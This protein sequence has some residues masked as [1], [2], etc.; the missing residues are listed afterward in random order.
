[1]TQLTILCAEDDPDDRLLL[2]DAMAE[3][4]GP[5]H[6]EFVEDGLDLL[7][8]L[9]SGGRWS[10]AEQARPALI[11]L[12]LNMPRMDGREALRE[13][14]ADPAIR[15]IPVVVMTTSGAEADVSFA[16]DHGASS[17]VVKPVTFDGLVEAMRDLSHY[18]ADLV[19]L[20][21]GRPVGGGTQP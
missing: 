10:G 16:H 7:D 19:E 15:Q 3:V 12:D 13:I 11:L 4:A 14:K 20:P 6:I 2:T 18:W 8:Y 1:M 21:A 9:R 17:F 5:P